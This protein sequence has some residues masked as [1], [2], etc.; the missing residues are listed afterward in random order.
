M[1]KAPATRSNIVIQHLKDWVEKLNK[2]MIL[3]FSEFVDVIAIKSFSD[4]R[5]SQTLIKICTN[6]KEFDESQPRKAQFWPA[7]ALTVYSGL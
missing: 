2:Y 5:I 4:K 6:P 3:L 1:R 7:S